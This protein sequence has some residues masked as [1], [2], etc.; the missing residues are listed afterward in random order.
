MSVYVL[1]HDLGS[2]ILR[3]DDAE[4]HEPEGR[5]VSSFNRLPKFQKLR[6]S[7]VPT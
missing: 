4:V 7:A 3:D 2:H 6:K 5:A 1:I